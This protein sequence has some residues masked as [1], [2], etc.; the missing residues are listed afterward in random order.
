MSLRKKITI[1]GVWGTAFA[2]GYLRWPAVLLI[3]GAVARFY[4]IA[5]D[6]L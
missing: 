1:L 6:D 3:A 2:A 4:L 5:A